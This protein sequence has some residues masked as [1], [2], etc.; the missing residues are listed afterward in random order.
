MAD[1][2]IPLW[3]YREGY[4]VS[5]LISYEAKIFD[6]WQFLP[7]A[8]QVSHSSKL[9]SEEEKSNEFNSWQKNPRWDSRLNSI[10][11]MTQSDSRMQGMQPEHLWRCRALSPVAANSKGRA[12]SAVMEKEA[13]KSYVKTIPSLV[14]PYLLFSCSVLCVSLPFCMFISS[15]CCI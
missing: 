14:F 7:A 13:S 3:S 2:V 5:G 10:M 12:D 11:P 9:L 1:Y 4:H 8:S 15:I 6:F